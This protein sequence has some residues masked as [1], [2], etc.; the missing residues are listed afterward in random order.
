MGNS[1]VGFLLLLRAGLMNG[2]LTLPMRFT[3]TPGFKDGSLHR[4]LVEHGHVLIAE[5]F[6]LPL[7]L[8]N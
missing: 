6:D 4:F 7:T 8:G 2:S 1:A 3:R 5:H